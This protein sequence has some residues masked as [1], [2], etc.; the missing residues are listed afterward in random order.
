MKDNEK[1]ILKISELKKKTEKEIE[2][3]NTLF[4]KTLNDLTKSFKQKYDKLK[5][6]ENELKELLQ[7]EVTKVKEKLENF[8]DNINNEL[9]I[10][11]KINKGIQNFEKEEKNM[12]KILTYIS[13]I[14]K[15]QKNMNLLFQEMISSLKFSFQEKESNIN[16]EEFYFNGTPIPNNIEIKDNTFIDYNNLDISWKIENIKNFDKI[17]FK[18]EFRKENEEFV[19]VYEG[20]KDNYTIN[21]LKNNTNYEIRICSIYNNVNGLW[22]EIKKLT[23]K[24]QL[25]VKFYLILQKKMNF[26]KK[27][28]N[29]VDIKVWNYYLEEV[30]MVCIVKI[31]MKNVIINLLQ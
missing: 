2:N 18:I 7:N 9:K 12:I 20:E 24:N 10:N 3:I 15:N 17:K 4:Q 13:K 6:E 14:S 8:L 1:Y 29:G 5:K 28:M 25:I 21:N 22:S 19:K 23:T 16:F 11:E 26:Y 27:F 30:E 31:F